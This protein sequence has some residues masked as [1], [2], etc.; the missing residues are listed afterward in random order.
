[1]KYYFARIEEFENYD[2]NQINKQ[3]KLFEN[4]KKLFKF[5]QMLLVMIQK[6]HFVYIGST[7]KEDVI[8]M[9]SFDKHPFQDSIINVDILEEKIESDKVKK[10]FEI[11]DEKKIEK[12]FI[13]YGDNYIVKVS[14]LPDGYSIQQLYTY[15]KNSNSQ[16]G[17][18][19][20]KNYAL[21][22]YKSLQKAKEIVSTYDTQYYSY[23]D[24]NLRFELLENEKEKEN[25]KKEIKN[26][27]NERLKYNEEKEKEFLKIT[28]GLYIVKISN[29]P[30]DYSVEEIDYILDGYPKPCRKRYYLNCVS[31]VYNSLKD[32][33]EIVMDFNGWRFR[34]EEEGN[35]LEFKLIKNEENEIK[36]EEN[37]IKKEEKKYYG[38]KISN[39]PI[40][41]SID[42][43]NEKFNSFQN[44]KYNCIKEKSLFYKD[45]AILKYNSLKYAKDTVSF[46][47]ACTTFDGNI[48]KVE[49]LE[50][51]KESQTEVCKKHTVFCASDNCEG[52]SSNFIAPNTIE[53]TKPTGYIGYISENVI[54]KHNLSLNKLDLKKTI[55]SEEFI[56]E[57]KDRLNWF[58]ICQYQK[59]SIS[60]MIKF[61]DYLSWKHV[62]EFQTLTE[63]FIH[64]FHNFVDWENISKKQVLCEAFIKKY[65][66]K[67]NWVNI[68]KHQTLTE[69]FI[70]VYKYLL[71]WEYLD[72]SKMSIDFIK[73]HLE[74]VD[75]KGL[76]KNII[77]RLGD[78]GYKGYTNDEF[79]CFFETVRAFKDILNWEMLLE[80]YNYV[81]LFKINFSFTKKFIEEFQDYIFKH[82]KWCFG[83]I[84]NNKLPIEI[85]RKH[86]DTIDWD[87]MSRSAW[88]TQEIIEEF[89]EYIHWEIFSTN[90]YFDMIENFI[91]YIDW[92]TVLNRK[93]YIPAWFVI[94]YQDKF[95][96]EKETEK[97]TFEVIE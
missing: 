14:N 63:E 60:F 94:K 91:E 71:H 96:P 4:L 36:N 50:K 43:L 32:A 38:V 90:I 30:I 7:N 31:L 54:R 61:S 2:E 53:S 40:G 70:D 23:F 35:I 37:E 85:I 48:L 84:L 64:Q 18:L 58:D 65:Y 1:M 8:R 47:K 82:D 78:K 22:K 39:L 28:S 45:Y 87:Q 29:L 24:K 83:I 9:K 51:E 67:V 25:E 19:Y 93:E 88:L 3:Y 69:N 62:S 15:L 44:P 68:S 81:N 72:Y 75:I 5:E 33:E 97:E 76:S 26:E 66:K 12:E 52:K 27:E 59:L 77:R 6:G 80:E 89:K 11:L 74:F 13:E 73:E 16:I 56:Q 79:D 17:I 41:Y 10:A 49:L 92:N 86:K 21:L 46:W 57:F 42:K 55:L 95:L 20:R 34:E